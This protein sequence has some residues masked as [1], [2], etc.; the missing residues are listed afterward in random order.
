[1]LRR[2]LD[3]INHRVPD[4][5]AMAEDKPQQFNDIDHEYDAGTGA[6]GEAPGKHIDAV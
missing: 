2:H 4:G 1:M 5:G 6:A 3:R